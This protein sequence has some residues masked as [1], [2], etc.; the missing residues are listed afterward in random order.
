[1]SSSSSSLVAE[2]EN[3]LK[4]HAR[5]IAEALQQQ[6]AAEQA[7]ASGDASKLQRERLIR[8]TY[9]ALCHDDPLVESD[10]ACHCLAAALLDPKAPYALSGPLVEGIRQLCSREEDQQ[11]APPTIAASKNDEESGT[12]NNV[13]LAA[14]STSSSPKGS[15][16]L[17]WAVYARIPLLCCQASSLSEIHS[18]LGSYRPPP[19]PPD[20]VLS[21][22]RNEQQILESLEKNDE[23]D[24]LAAML[25]QAEESTKKM[26]SIKDTDGA[27]EEEIWAAESD[28][29]DFEFDSGFSYEQQVN[30]LQ[31]SLAEWMS[32]RSDPEKLS[33]PPDVTNWKQVR[34]A[35]MDLT[36]QLTYR[37]VQSLW[38]SGLGNDAQANALVG[39]TLS[40]R[41]PSDL[42]AHFTMTL[43]MPPPAPPAPQTKSSRPSIFDSPD[44]EE[45]VLQPQR[46]LQAMA[47]YPLWVLRDA[48]V[49]L[50]S[51]N[52]YSKYLTLLQT[53]IAVDAASAIS[54]TAVTGKKEAMSMAPATYVGLASLS[55]LCQQVISAEE[56][57]TS[58]NISNH[59]AV[60]R[61]R[62]LRLAVWE[63]ADDLSHA[64]ER[65]DAIRKATTTKDMEAKSSDAGKENI[66]GSDWIV[67]TIL[68]ML[69]IMSNQRLLTGNSIMPNA[70]SMAQRHHQQQISQQWSGL[71]QSG[72]FKQW[73]LRLQDLQ[74]GSS[75]S[76][77][78]ARVLWRLVRRSLMNVIAQSMPATSALGKYAWRFPGF[79]TIADIGPSRGEEAD[80]N[81]K[82]QS[83]EL[84]FEN[85]VDDVLWNLLAVELAGN[86]SSTTPTIQWKSSAKKA[87]TGQPLPTR[88]QSQQVSWE[89]FRKLCQN[90]VFVLKLAAE[91]ENKKENVDNDNGKNETFRTT[92]TLQLKEHQLILRNFHRLIDS[93]VACPLLA[94]L[95]VY[96]MQPST[97][98]GTDHDMQ[99]SGI[100]KQF[101]AIHEALSQYKAPPPLPPSS[102]PSL[103]A[104]AAKEVP[105][106]LKVDDE[107]ATE[108]QD[109]SMDSG[110]NLMEPALAKEQSQNIS[111]QDDI[112]RTRKLLKVA[113]SLLS[114]TPV[115]VTS[116]NLTSSSKTD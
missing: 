113:Q 73:L 63:I 64:L 69:E 95:F 88:D 4:F 67:W 11:S 23:A 111:L 92:K 16:I 5:A 77:Q 25:T 14:I 61:Y 10:F 66:T 60:E 44:D 6:E 59:E 107:N 74:Q 89:A 50:P 97:G 84:I 9:I 96:D 105:I 79:A 41:G 35:V 56:K 47:W 31:D 78:T 76:N 100:V 29:S 86:S 15:A 7:Y 45:H 3:F 109:A 114:S 93:L 12:S 85:I 115:T 54:T 87:P 20:P 70:E 27:L 1:M 26:D 32:D 24:R 82:Q 21:G 55:A 81:K 65:E 72:F 36:S 110:G 13:N 99:C 19:P 68:P 102:S 75:E 94:K 37:K 51:L 38:T 104:T 52:H 33:K 34:H 22:Q 8:D 42:L 46:Q 58:T 17:A 91:A 80:G 116:Q 30:D 83:S 53:L 57:S 98:N 71:L 106:K 43:L 2:D 62:A 90:V 28:P 39:G 18:Y 108:A 112:H 101:D 48:A 40:G 103:G 49:N